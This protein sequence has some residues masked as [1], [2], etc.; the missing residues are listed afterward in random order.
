MATA[1]EQLADAIKA[2]EDAAARVDALKKQS[3]IL[4]ES[5]QQEISKLSLP[6][7][8]K[9]R[10]ISLNY[11]PARSLK[12]A[13]ALVVGHLA[14]RPTTYSRWL[15]RDVNHLAITFN[16]DCVE[17]SPVVIPGVTP[18]LNCFHCLNCLNCLHWF[19]CMH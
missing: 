16:L 13:F 14:L 6:V 18:C 7:T 17:V 19:Y 11:K 8:K 3:R 9:Q 12:V 10:M 5:L 1:G 15:N 4:F 2:A